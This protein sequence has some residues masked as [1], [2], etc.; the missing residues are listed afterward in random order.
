MFKFTRRA[1]I[2][3]AVALSIASSVMAADMTF[4]LAT[5]GTEND[6]SQ[7]LCVKYSR[8]WFLVLLT[9]TQDI[10]G[11]CLLKVQSSMQFPEVT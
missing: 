2:G 7:L 1:A 10:M 8:L 9:L 4:T 11:R 6:A 5:S 3:S